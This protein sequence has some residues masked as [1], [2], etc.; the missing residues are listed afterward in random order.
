MTTKIIATIGPASNNKK[1]IESMRDKGMTIARINLSHT[2]LEELEDLIKLIQ[3]AKVK[4]MIDLQGA[5]I[6]LCSRKA[7]FL[8]EDSTLEISK[9]LAEDYS[10]SRP[11]V[12]DNL[13]IGDLISV[14]G[15]TILLKVTV[16][17]E[18]KIICLVI[19]PGLISSKKC[20]TLHSTKYQV[21]I[22][23]K[24][25]KKA[26]S[27]GKE[28]GVDYIALSF[29]NQAKDIRD[30]RKLTTIPIIS[31]IES[32]N[33]LS[34]IDGIISESDGI[35][36]DRGDL[37]Q[38]IA[39]ERVPLIQ[40]II[41]HKCL[42]EKKPLF[43]ATNL[44]ESMIDNEKPTRAETNDI[45]NTVLDGASGLVLAAETAIGKNPIKAVGML[46]KLCN[47]AE[48]AIIE[49]SSTDAVV[50]RLEAL[51][52]LTN[53]TIVSNLIQP[54]GGRLINQQIRVGE[55]LLSS[56]K[57]IPVSKETLM[58]AE[59]ICIG[60][61]SPITGFMK[62][63]ELTSV[64]DNM[65]LPDGVVWTIPL[66]L[67]LDKQTVASLDIGQQII[68][69]DN[70]GEEYALMH[71]EEIY[72]FD[73]KELS[74]KLYDTISKEHPGVVQVDKL[75][76]YF[77]GGKVSL[78]KRLSS[79]FK[80]FEL[81][82]AQTR[83]IF[84][85]LGW[86]TIVGFHTRNVIHKAHEFIQLQAVRKVNADGL[87]INPVI[88]KKKKGDFQTKFILESYKIMKTNFY[89]KGS[90]VVSAFST[91]S[92]YAGP[93]E[94]I[95]T[96]ICRQNFG[97]SHF[98]VGRDHTGVKDFYGPHESQELFEQL[99]LDLTPIFFNKVSF[100][101]TCN[102]YVEKCDHSGDCK[103]ISGTKIRE[104][105]LS[106]EQPPEWAMRPEI[107][108]MLLDAQSQGKELFV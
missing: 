10:L 71:V 82:P 3:Q 102:S 43:V 8:E 86:N 77:I 4:V 76:P 61:F 84:N 21:P 47:H 32:K 6:R 73:K 49:E 22:I 27:L 28:L 92:R 55:G 56:L 108:Q 13:S 95:F 93:R 100:C 37:G 9:D 107:S 97:C 98:I 42:S 40:K 48:L 88:G 33:A 96:A 16:I 31:K 53:P 36:I 65:K 12:L 87:F 30:L 45:I 46:R 94:A 67:D 62:K 26:I 11:E 51:N 85:E 18:D 14:A 2:P 78:I 104:M 24:I 35:L 41:A 20:I 5:E 64:L 101:H 83:K 59:Q 90:A 57:K 72:E 70:T 39:E 105:L 89:E 50:G 60:T 91:F 81:T 38:E 99:D 69:T 23:T 106:G 80:E 29:V 68:L 54:H 103:N 44:L 75:K 1:V 7:K 66:L 17:Q 74:S 15:G 63:A 25:D 79:E 52:Y 19:R 34:D 58:D